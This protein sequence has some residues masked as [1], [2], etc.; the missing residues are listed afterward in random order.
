MTTQR[1]RRFQAWHTRLALTA[2]VCAPVAA[3]AAGQAPSPT[4]RN[5]QAAKSASALPS[6][7]QVFAQYR[8][9]VGGEGAVRKYRSRRATGRFDLTTQ[10]MGGDFEMVAAAPDRMK[11]E[12]DLSGLGKLVR[13]YDGKVGWSIDPAIGPRLLSG[14]EL[15]EVRHSADF[16]YDLRDPA[17]FASATVLEQAAFEGKTCYTVKIVRP[18]GLE[19]LEYYDVE[20]G[21]LAG[22]RMDSS[23]PMGTVPGVV[24]VIS[25]YKDFGGIL[26]A[27]TAR[28]RAMGIESV[29][30][31]SAVEYDT[32]PADAFALPPAIAALAR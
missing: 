4:T 21:L 16:Y 8:K 19:V 6:A 22:F 11:L 28:Q 27:T 14:R 23:S 3:V 20:T 32:V 12:I 13:G 26:T 29:L 30:T 24:T 18:S 9:A 7:A 2:L 15:D 1:R 17:T 10:G 25:G 31:I 5:A